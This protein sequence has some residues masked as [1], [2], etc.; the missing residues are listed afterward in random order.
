[1]P[2]ISQATVVNFF[3]SSQHLLAVIQIYPVV[4]VVFFCEVDKLDTSKG[5]GG[6]GRQR[7]CTDLVKHTQKKHVC[8]SSRPPPPANELMHVVRVGGGIQICVAFIIVIKHF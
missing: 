8:H 6:G 5:S 2:S 1:M 7:E 3:D 4:A